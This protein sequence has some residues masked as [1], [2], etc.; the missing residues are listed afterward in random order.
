MTI[1]RGTFGSPVAFQGARQIVAR[2]GH[3][4]SLVE[5]SAAPVYIDL[6]RT[7]RVETRTGA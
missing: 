7:C 2:A 1:E 4:G 5:R 6:A 3:S